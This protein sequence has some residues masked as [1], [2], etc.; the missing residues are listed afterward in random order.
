M[1]LPFKILTRTNYIALNR[2]VQRLSVEM[3]DALAF[4]EKIE[5]GDLDATYTGQYLSSELAQ[6][7]QAMKQE[8]Q[9]LAEKEKERNWA[10]KGFAK[11]VDI[12][13]TD[14]DSINELAQN[15][16]AAVVSYMDA[17]QGGIF[18]MN[19]DNPNDTYLEL[20]A[21]YAYNR[22]KF[23][24][25]KILPGEGLIGQVYLEGQTTY[26]TDIP[27]HYLKITSGLGET[28]PKNIIILPLKYNKEV[29]GVIELATFHEWK[30]YQID[31]IERLSENIATA[32]ASVKI[33]QNTRLLL[34]ESQEHSEMLLSQEEE[35][36]Q[37]LE[38]LQ[39]TQEELSR[40]Q[41]DLQD[42]LRE[43]ENK[44]NDLK[45]KENELKEAQKL[46][47]NIIDSIP[48]AVYWKDR[49]L[50]YL[51]CNL[52]FAKMA[53]VEAKDIIGKSDENMPWQARAEDI[54][55]SEINILISRKPKLGVEEQVELGKDKKQRWLRVNRAPLLDIEGQAYGL[56]GVFEDI[57]EEKA[58]QAE[59]KEKMNELKATQAEMLKNQKEVELINKKLKT[60]ENVLQKALLKAKE[61]EKE[62]KAK[63]EELR[64]VE[65][66]QR[67]NMEFLSQINDEFEAKQKELQD[68]KKKLERNASVLQKALDDA[69]R[70]TQ[71]AE[72]KNAEL[73]AAEEELR[74]QA[75]ELKSTNEQFEAKQRELL[76]TQ[77]K[78]ERNSSVLE[79]AF[80]VSHE[81]ERELQEKNAQLA[82]IE[83]EVRQNMEELQAVNEQLEST[84]QELQMQKTALD[85][86]A[87]VAI[88]DKKGTITYINDKFCE[89]SKY[90]REELIGQ[91]HRILN[92]GHHPK[93]F[94]VDMWKNIAKGNV[95]RGE[96]KNKAK[97]GSFYWVATTIAPELDERGQAK[98]YLA[99]RFDITD[100]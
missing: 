6:A 71:E 10:N 39:A 53:G 72:I 32:I 18:V 7:L 16:I 46:L 65:E 79:K 26:F 13:R 75:E 52:A 45:N 27:A 70:K 47:Q 35:M 1:K 4:V 98:T 40:K 80:T 42:A 63:N 29:Y 37:N 56:L 25:R 22:K 74:Q 77:Q 100:R 50:K 92:S 21:S 15:I 5:K 93:S 55:Q 82:A 2:Q 61:R 67:Q 90:S 69:K 14:S 41:F 3:K 84:Q 12:F 34:M 97:D 48:V 99:I 89:I 95:W 23:L 78:L 58:R 51:G 49:D 94:F 59:L 87:I 60:N 38:E 43:S 24:E 96:V 28:T 66:E 68:A 33:S 8:F 20:I 54:H 86:A 9:R 81:R 30:S 73:R 44:A 36:R 17:N 11:F 31:F 19:D 85:E 83:E 91:N 62:I 57:S 76:K 88:T 64:S